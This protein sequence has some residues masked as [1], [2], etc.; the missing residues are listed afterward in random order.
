M[1]HIDHSNPDQK[2]PRT[3]ASF[4]VMTGIILLALAAIFTYIGNGSAEN[5]TLLSPQ[6]D[7]DG[8]QNR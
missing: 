3:F 1:V 7:R 6:S 4:I 8:I 2:R 5:E